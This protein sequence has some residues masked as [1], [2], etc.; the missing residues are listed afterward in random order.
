MA[1]PAPGGKPRGGGSDAKPRRRPGIIPPRQGRDKGVSR[2]RR[3]AFGQDAA[4]PYCTRT[5]WPRTSPPG[6]WPVWTLK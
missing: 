2:L 6:F 4:A 1:E 5:T 3:A